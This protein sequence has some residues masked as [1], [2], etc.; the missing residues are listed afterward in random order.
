MNVRPLNEKKYNI[1]KHR[2]AELYHFCMQYPEWK[3]ELNYKTDNIN[4]IDISDMPVN[5]NNVSSVEKFTPRTLDKNSLRV[6]LNKREEIEQKMYERKM[7]EK[8]KNRPK[9]RIKI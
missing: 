7:A 4:S 8:I 6:R 2:F 9:I 5:H 1:T 3:D